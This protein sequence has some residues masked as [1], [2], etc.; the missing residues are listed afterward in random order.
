MT[1]MIPKISVR[2]DATRKSS[3]PYCSE[4][5]HWMRKVARS[6]QVTKAKSEAQQAKERSAASA[7][8]ATPKDPAPPVRR[9]APLGGRSAATG[10]LHPAAA[11]R[12]AQCLRRNADQ[13]VLL[14]FDLAQVDVLHRVVGLG[15]RERASRAVDGGL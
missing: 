1:P 2:P 6:M 9:V 5:R 13:I 8:P 4:F 11:R 14:A 7:H 15:Q 10:G 3:S 12:I